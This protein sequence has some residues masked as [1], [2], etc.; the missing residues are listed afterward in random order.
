MAGRRKG[1]SLKEPPRITTSPP[2]PSHAAELS[3][4]HPL[5]EGVTRRVFM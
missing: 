2:R 3:A 4:L 5:G 1:W